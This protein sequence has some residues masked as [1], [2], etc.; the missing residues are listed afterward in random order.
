MRNL[1]TFDVEEWFHT[2][3][4]D[5]YIGWEQWGYLESRAVANVHRLGGWGYFRF[6]P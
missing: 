1:L 4:L 3:A 2:S 6:F 5:A